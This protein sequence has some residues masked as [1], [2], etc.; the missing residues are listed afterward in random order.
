[1]AGDLLSSRQN[2]PPT[3]FRVNKNVACKNIIDKDT[4]YNTKI[5]L[6]LGLVWKLST[7]QA[8]YN[9]VCLKF[10]YRVSHIGIILMNG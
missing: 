5:P 4:F 7:N 1:M 3:V 6:L 9:A 8:Q 2:P 10:N